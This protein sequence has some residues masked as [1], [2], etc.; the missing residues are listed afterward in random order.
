[1]TRKDFILIAAALKGIHGDSEYIGEIQFDIV[2]DAL[3]N[4]LAT[5]NPRFN[6]ATFLAAC[7]VPA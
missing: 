6:R 7:G 1:M 5:S 2:C 4:A 3:A